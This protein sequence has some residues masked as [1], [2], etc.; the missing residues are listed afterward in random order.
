MIGR[1][2]KNNRDRDELHFLRQNAGLIN[3]TGGVYQFAQAASRTG[4][5]DWRLTG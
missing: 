2:A 1:R 3:V 5:I 4:I